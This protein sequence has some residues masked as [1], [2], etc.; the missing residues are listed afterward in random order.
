LVKRIFISFFPSFIFFPRPSRASAPHTCPARP[1]AYPAQ[2]RLP[3]AASPACRSSGLS[4]RASPI[5]TSR[6]PP[7]LV[8]AARSPP[9]HLAPPTAPTPLGSMFR[10]A[11]PAPVTS[12]SPTWF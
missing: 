10:S 1:P 3:V 11:L 12:S 5:L 9:L 6:R 4:T 7:P 8:P 2:P